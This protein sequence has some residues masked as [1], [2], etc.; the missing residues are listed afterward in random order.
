MKW[1]I[2]HRGASAAYPENTM[3]AFRKAIDMGAN[4]L[5][6]DVHVCKSGEAV[7]IHDDTLER[8]TSGR[9]Y[10]AAH[11]LSDLKKL[12]A[13]RGEPIPT[14]EEVLFEFAAKIILFIEIK[15]AGASLPA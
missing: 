4:A 3:L 5:E 10:V 15:S 2:G 1:K 11:T 8:T 13:G 9:G 7:V 6:F 12:D 14:L